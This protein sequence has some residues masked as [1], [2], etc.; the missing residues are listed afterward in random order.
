MIPAIS[1]IWFVIQIAFL[2]FLSALAAAE[3]EGESL[4][5]GGF[6]IQG[7]NWIN[8]L[9]IFAVIVCAVFPVVRAWL[10]AKP[11]QNASDHG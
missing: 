5:P 4:L 3:S 11:V 1:F 9:L 7:M 2:M 6:V 8:T 10:D